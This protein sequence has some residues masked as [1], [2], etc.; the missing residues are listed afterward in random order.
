MSAPPPLQIDRYEGLYHDN[1]EFIIY[2]T[3]P[4]L[5]QFANTYVGKTID[6]LEEANKLYRDVI[7]LH[8]CHFRS[9][10]YFTQA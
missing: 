5:I 8:C 10:Q 3:T 6:K 1:N 2:K 9:G 7:S 4:M